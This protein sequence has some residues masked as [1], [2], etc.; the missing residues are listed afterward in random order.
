[1]KQLGPKGSGWKRL[2][3]GHLQRQK[4]GLGLENP[5]DCFN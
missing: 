2:S 5:A 4:F 3:E 1:M